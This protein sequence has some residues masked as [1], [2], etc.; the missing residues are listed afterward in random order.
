[1][2]DPIKV[3]GGDKAVD[4][5][6]SN[7]PLGVEVRSSPLEVGIRNTTPL[8][9][10]IKGKSGVRDFLDATNVVFAILMSFCIV[11]IS[12]AT[13]QYTKYHNDNTIKQNEAQMAIDNEKFVA[14][15]ANFISSYRENNTCE[16]IRIR[17]DFLSDLIE[18]Q[19]SS[20]I[21]SRAEAFRFTVPFL[22][23]PE[24]APSVVTN[25]KSQ[26]IN[27]EATLH[28]FA[29]G[30]PCAAEIANIDSFGAEIRITDT[31]S[32]FH[33]SHI[34]FNA[35]NNNDIKHTIRVFLEEVSFASDVASTNASDGSGENT[36]DA[37]DVS[38]DETT[39]ALDNS[40]DDA[41]DATD[42]SDTDI[43]EALA[44][45]V[46]GGKLKIAPLGLVYP[47]SL[48]VA[49]PKSFCPKNLQTSVC[50]YHRNSQ[51]ND[52]F[53]SCEGFDEKEGGFA[54]VDLKRT[55][56]LLLRCTSL[57]A[58]DP[59]AKGVSGSISA[60]FEEASQNA[61]A[62]ADEGFSKEL[63][64]AEIKEVSPQQLEETNKVLQEQPESVVGWV[65]LGLFKNN[66]WT[67]HPCKRNVSIE[68]D[69]N[70]IADEFKPDKQWKSF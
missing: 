55:S 33:G 48:S 27:Y 6:V 7:S 59:V 14:E 43:S 62:E 37:S 36:T 22:T 26:L 9:V 19:L 50:F 58:S 35:H 46:D 5:R 11:L 67:A 17:K 15:Q 61:L 53:I 63:M 18:R 44:P 13:A 20:L 28:Q 52:T 40:G 34:R 1:M 70:D 21:Q 16:D 3:E 51:G 23:T 29:F 64:S 65:Y 32:A 42:G 66:R 41:A 24:T 38:G 49:I 56:E 12:L 4:I 47:E 39:H 68:K 8:E 60:K 57:A 45:A 25:D 54:S 10:D 2:T 69:C 31:A 30:K